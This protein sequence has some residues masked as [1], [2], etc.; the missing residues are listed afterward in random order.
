MK[1]AFA[2][3][4]LA[5]ACHGDARE[6]AP[7]PSRA[8]KPPEVQEG[9]SPLEPSDPERRDSAPGSAPPVP[10]LGEMRGPIKDDG[11]AGSGVPGYKRA[12][13]SPLGPY[14]DQYLN[15]PGYDPSACEGSR[16]MSNVAVGF[17]C[18]F[19]ED[20]SSAKPLRIRCWPL[21]DKKR[22]SSTYSRALAELM[23]CPKQR[24]GDG[25]QLPAD[26]PISAGTCADGTRFLREGYVHQFRTRFYDG[27]SCL[28]SVFSV[29]SGRAAIVAARSIAMSC[30]KTDCAEPPL[31]SCE[32]PR[33]FIRR[34]PESLEPGAAKRAARTRGEHHAEPVPPAGVARLR[35]G[36]GDA[37]IAERGWPGCA[38]PEEAE[39][40]RRPIHQHFR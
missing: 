17:G 25:V 18:G 2:P 9:L 40:P 4:L 10:E 20:G 22:A 37:Q 7:L 27:E 15:A 1:L 33:R 39:I 32:T 24:G 35:T 6:T 3:L 38:T 11:L 5:F 30:G 19:D 29:A 31:T 21:S 13:C 8:S 28:E 23:A 12:G 16:R 26:A 34:S 14:E 36:A